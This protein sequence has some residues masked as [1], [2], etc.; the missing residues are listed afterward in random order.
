MTNN[1]KSNGHPRELFSEDFYWEPSGE[2]RELLKEIMDSNI[3][4]DEFREFLAISQNVESLRKG[5]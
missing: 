4:K 2:W 1:K 5:H 3:S